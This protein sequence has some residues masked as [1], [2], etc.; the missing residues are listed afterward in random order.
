MGEWEYIERVL[1]GVRMFWYQCMVSNYMGSC[2]LHT[3]ANIF[4]MFGLWFCLLSRQFRRT[5]QCHR[6]WGGLRLISG[7]FQSWNWCYQSW[8]WRMLPGS[9]CLNC[10]KLKV[11]RAFP[12]SAT[13]NLD[14]QSLWAL[15]V[16]CWQCLR[17]V[18][19]QLAVRGHVCLFGS[20]YPTMGTFLKQCLLSHVRSNNLPRI[21]KKASSLVLYLTS[22]CDRE[23]MMPSS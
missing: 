7:K 5:S 6:W 20:F 13:F 22:N 16:N 10:W 8:S 15:G 19:L 23:K 14:A 2:F 1:W 18:T 11:D 4:L 9:R 17:E 12:Q 21:P 3:W